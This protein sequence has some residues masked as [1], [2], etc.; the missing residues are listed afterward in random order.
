MRHAL[1]CRRQFM[2]CSNA[3]GEQVPEAGLRLL[4]FVDFLGDFLGPGFL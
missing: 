3:A 4:G 2:D 1:P